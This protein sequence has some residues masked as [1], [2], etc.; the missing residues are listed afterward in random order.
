MLGS[1]LLWG[2][3]RLYTLMY[4]EIV[5]ENHDL[6][7]VGVSNNPTWLREGGPR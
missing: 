3:P 6:H 1:A 7:F 4:S 2:K 5:F